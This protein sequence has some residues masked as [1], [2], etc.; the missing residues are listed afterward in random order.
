MT[1]ATLVAHRASEE[2]D[3]NER[4]RRRATARRRWGLG[5]SYLALILVT[6]LMVFPPARH[7]AGLVHTERG[8][9][10]MAPEVHPIRVHP[11]ELPVA[12]PTPASRPGDAQHHR[13]RRLCDHFLGIL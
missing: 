3:E 6:I 2:Y 1:T 13:L 4:L 11:R 8:D 9:A 12:V 7:P 10:D 5:F